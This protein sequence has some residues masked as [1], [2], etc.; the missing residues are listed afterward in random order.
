MAIQF[1]A[2]PVANP[3]YEYEGVLY[4]W[5]NDRWIVDSTNTTGQDLQAVCDNG[6]TTTTGARFAD[7]KVQ[8]QPD[9][10]INIGD[11]TTTSNV[12]LFAFNNDDRP[13]VGAIMARTMGD[14]SAFVAYDK[15]GYDR[16]K[17]KGD[18]SATFAA[19]NLEISVNGDI[20]CGIGGKVD[21]TSDSGFGAQINSEPNSGSFIS[22]HTNVASAFGY[23]FAA[24]RGSTN[25]FYVLN[26][27]EL[28]AKNY[29]IDLLDTLP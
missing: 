29:R 8:I 26:T 17:I 11:D 10:R 12:G 5:D 4:V 1:P 20:N 9:G 2:D 28:F 23:S 19:D 13:N 14:G 15:V 24:F 22:Q 7:G 6:N 25:G 18:G 27:G 3:T 16:V 21:I